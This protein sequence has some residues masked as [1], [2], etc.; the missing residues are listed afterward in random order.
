MRTVYL[1]YIRIVTINENIV[2]YKV[3]VKIIELRRNNLKG[4]KVPVYI[5]LKS[6]R[7]DAD[8]QQSSRSLF[9]TETAIPRGVV[10]RKAC[11]D[12][13]GDVLDLIFPIKEGQMDVVAEL[14]D[15]PLCN[16]GL[17]DYSDPLFPKLIDSGFNKIKFVPEPILLVFGMEIYYGL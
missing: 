13:L 16:V 15:D 10:A 17:A 9:R 5:S 1:N 3:S 4:H 8:F 14:V 7:L 11:L 6:F 2:K 12:K